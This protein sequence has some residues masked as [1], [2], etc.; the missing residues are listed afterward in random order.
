MPPG[1]A[2]KFLLSSVIASGLLKNAEGDFVLTTWLDAAPQI[3]QRS[4]ATL[5]AER[6][7]ERERLFQQPTVSTC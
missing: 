6:H 1:T 7:R 3:Q 2:L 5:A 4:I